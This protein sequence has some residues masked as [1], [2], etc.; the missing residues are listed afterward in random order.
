M[1][2]TKV[3]PTIVSGQKPVFAD[4][5]FVEAHR[6]ACMQAREYDE[7]HHPH[8]IVILPGHDA[9][10]KSRFHVGNAVGAN[11][12]AI[13]NPWQRLKS[14][15]QLFQARNRYLLTSLSSRLIVR[16]ACR[17]AST[18]KIITHMKS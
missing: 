12:V 2:A 1:A 9:Q 4:Q 15:P 5:S 3:A 6:A 11:S 13:R 14:H 7:N 10:A 16:P 8:E 17:P 18:M